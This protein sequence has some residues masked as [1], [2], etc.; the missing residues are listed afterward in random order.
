MY[1]WDSYDEQDLIPFNMIAQAFA[2][3]NATKYRLR[4][5]GVPLTFSWDWR[6]QSM[7]AG[8]WLA[9]FADPDNLCESLQASWGNFM[10]GSP[11][12][13]DQTFVDAE[14]QAALVEADPNLRARYL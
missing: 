6:D 2:T 9:D 3:L 14:I 12:P 8:D 4:I 5:E 10:I 1:I 13:E 7:F 11:Y